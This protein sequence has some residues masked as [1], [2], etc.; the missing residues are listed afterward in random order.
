MKSRYLARSY[1]LGRSAGDRNREQHR[2][3]GQAGRLS[4]VRRVVQKPLAALP[5]D[6]VDHR[7]LHVAELGGRADRLDLDFL[8]EV[9]ARLGSRDAVARASEV[10]AVDQELVLVGA[11]AERGHGSSRCRSTARSARCPGRPDEVE[12]AGPPRRDRSEILG[13]EASSESAALAPRCASRLPRPRPIPRRLPASGQPFARWWRQRRCG[14][15]LRDRSQIP[16]SS[17]SSAYES[18]R[19]SRE[20]QLPFLVRGHA[21]P[22][23][24]SAP[25]T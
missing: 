4:V 8:N 24:Q 11:G 17:M 19:Q 14:C 3:A 1:P 16:R 21:S 9:D 7:A 13:A 12:H 18:R 25:A 6:D 23:R 5:G 2:L 20:P 10:R 15:P 22:G